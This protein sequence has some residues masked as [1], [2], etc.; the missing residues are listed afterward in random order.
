[1]DDFSGS[2]PSAYFFKKAKDKEGGNQSTKGR[3]G[4]ELLGCLR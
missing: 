3:V 2:V 4:E 1:M